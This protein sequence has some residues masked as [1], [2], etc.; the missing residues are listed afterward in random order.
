[1]GKHSGTPS[2]TLGKEFFL[3]K[4]LPRVLHSGKTFFFKKFGRRR[5]RQTFPECTIFGTRGRPLSRERRPRRLFPEC[6]CPFLECIWHSGKH[7]SPI[8]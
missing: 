5:H 6:F 7:V 2:A 8:V 1:L 3:N 4:F